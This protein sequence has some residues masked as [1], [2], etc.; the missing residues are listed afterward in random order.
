MYLAVMAS[1]ADDGDGNLPQNHGVDE[2]IVIPMDTNNNSQTLQTQMASMTALLQGMSEKLEGVVGRIGHVEN[3]LSEETEQEEAEQAELA[4]SGNN[5]PDIAELLGQDNAVDNSAADASSLER[6]VEADDSNDT[7]LAEFLKQ[8][9]AVE[10]L[11]ED[12]DVRVA[13]IINQLFRKKMDKE[14]YKTL[15]ASM[16]TARP[17]NCE[18]LSLVQT[19]SM[20]W[21]NLSDLTK[22]RDRQLQS[23]QKALVRS[24]SIMTKIFHQLVDAKGDHTK[25]NVTNLLKMT[26][27]SL[28]LMGDLN[29]SVNMF[30]RG[31][32]KPELKDNFKKLCAETVPYTKELFGDELPKLAKEIGE[33]A[34]ISNK[35]KGTGQLAAGN[36]YRGKMFNRFQ[37]RTT[38]YNPAFS[39]HSSNRGAARGGFN[40]QQNFRPRRGMKQ[41]R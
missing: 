21:S 5:M 33:T 13:S 16:E 34:K 1:N 23:C 26:N 28:A 29:F 32:M 38:P 27:D 10:A 36:N 41:S 20:L 12:V 39:G 3:Y 40:R 35:F 31:L 4:A 18:G 15:T 22:S 17:K 9:E 14:K 37:R 6:K 11:D 7:L 2:A 19:N 24:A 8:A 30:R 25:L